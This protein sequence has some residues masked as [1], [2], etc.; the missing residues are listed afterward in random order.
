MHAEETYWE[1]LGSPWELPR[2]LLGAPRSPN[3]TQNRIKSK[4]KIKAKSESEL[5]SES[6]SKQNPRE[7]LPKSYRNPMEKQEIL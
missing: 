2:E 5:K 3:R 7:I 6:K 1:V 4:I